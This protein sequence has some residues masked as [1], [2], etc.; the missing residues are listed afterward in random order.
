MN[1]L[2]REF[3]NL[4]VLL[5]ARTITEI[6]NYF[7]LDS[8]FNLYSNSKFSLVPLPYLAIIQYGQSK[9]HFPEAGISG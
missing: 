5:V 9:W 3:F 7:R 8:K 4:K 1:L 2:K 6:E